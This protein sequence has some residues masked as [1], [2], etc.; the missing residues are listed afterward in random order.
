MTKHHEELTGIIET[1]FMYV[2]TNLRRLTIDRFDEGDIP[3][4][5]HIYHAL[6]HNIKM[7]EDYARRA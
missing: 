6:N 4:P 5:E 2:N 7:I 3:T 1:Y